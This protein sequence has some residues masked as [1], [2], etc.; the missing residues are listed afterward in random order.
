MSFVLS[1]G[2][3]L[4]EGD[5]SEPAIRILPSGSKGSITLSNTSKDTPVAVDHKSMDEDKAKNSLVY[6]REGIPPLPA[7]V[8]QSI[9]KGEFVEFTSLLPESASCE[10]EP[11]MEVTEEVAVLTYAAVRGKKHL[12][13]I[14]ELMAYAATI[15]KGARDYMVIRIG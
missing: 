8:V 13:D 1:L 5:S 7:K 4:K 9:E 2:V 15:V 12:E 14:P 11:F 10:E 3:S 6:V